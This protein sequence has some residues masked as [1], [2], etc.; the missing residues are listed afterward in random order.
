MPEPKRALIVVNGLNEPSGTVR[1]AQYQPYFERSQQWRASFVSRRS[2]KWTHRTNRTYRPTAPLIVPLIHRPVASYNRRWERRRED[3]IVRQAAAVDLVYLV[4]VPALTLYQRLRALNGPVVIADFNDALWLPAFQNGGWQDWD[5]VLETAHGVICENGYVAG[6]AKRHNANVCVVP[7]SPQIEL[8]D[9]QRSAGPRQPG[10]I[11][12]GW[13]GSPENAGSLHR[14]FEPLEDVAGR[15]PGLQVRIVG[16]DRASLPR[17]EKVQWSCLPSYRQ[18]DMIRETAGF[19]VGLFPMFHTE[20][21]LARGNLKAMIYM[22]AG[23][24]VLCE[25]YGENRSLVEDGVNGALAA[26][27]EQWAHKLEWLATDHTSR[28]RLAQCG[29]ET[30]RR[31]F[32]G[33]VVFAQLE[34][35]FTRLWTAAGRDVRASAATS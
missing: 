1:A 10:K 9:R 20:E 14:I 5:T 13:I 31:R 25:D 33:E 8:Y 28:Q 16:A 18:P 3:E 32:S 26:T 30:I 4:K 22:S 29:T 21:G 12:F 6:Y 15:V 17:F 2:Q 7:D 35:A 27:S 11:V 19:D 23:A 34:D 24:A